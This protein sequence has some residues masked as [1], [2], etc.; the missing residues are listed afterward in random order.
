MTFVTYKFSSLRGIRTHL[1]KK[2]KPTGSPIPQMD[3]VSE[4]SEQSVAYT[5]KSEFAD[6]DI[7]YTFAEILSHDIENKLV[8]IG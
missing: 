8:Y 3:G 7:L 1:G 4:M 2:H 5:F 6:E